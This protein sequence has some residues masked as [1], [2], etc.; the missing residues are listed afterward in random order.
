MYHGYGDPI[1]SPYR[2]VLFYEELA[3]LTGGYDE[4]QRAARLFMV[5]EWGTGS[6]APDEFGNGTEP[7]GY[8]VDAQHDV[9]TALEE[10]V[11]NGKA[12]SSIVAT[13][14]ANDDP[15]SG[16][17][18][19]TMPLCPFPAEAVF[20][21]RGDVNDAAS[22]SCNDNQRLLLT[23]PNGRQAGVYGPEDQPAFPPDV[24]R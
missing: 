6:T 15:T 24:I 16:I 10:W 11:E 20:N 5:P 9:L 12:P 3:N 18:D 14:Y 21:G 23:G 13:H 1:I 17:V 4:L 2:S 19:R 22:W 7:T 8:P